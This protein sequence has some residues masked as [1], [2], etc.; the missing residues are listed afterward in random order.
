MKHLVTVRA[1]RAHIAARYHLIS[2]PNL[3]DRDKVV[4]MNEPA[5]DVAVFRL[6][7]EAAY[8]AV[9]AREPDAFMACGRIAL[10]RV[11][12]DSAASAFFKLTRVDFRRV[13]DRRAGSGGFNSRG[14]EQ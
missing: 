1:D 4:N 13:F 9:A 8:G 6:E 14:P 7:V 3:G 2:L 5:P 10:I 11:H 12:G